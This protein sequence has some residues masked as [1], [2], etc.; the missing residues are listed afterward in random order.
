MNACIL[1][2]EEIA[3]ACPHIHNARLSAL[4]DVTDTACKYQKC[5]LTGLGRTLI[6]SA[7]TKHCIKKIDRLLGNSHL[8]S[9]RKDIYKALA[10]RFVQVGSY[11]VIL[12]DWSQINEEAGFH[13]LRAS[14]ASEGRAITLYEEV[15]PKNKSH[16]REVH[17]AFLDVLQYI[18]PADVQPLLITDAG[19]KN[20]WFKQVQRKG[21]Y[22]LGRIR[23][24]TQFKTQDTEKW[25][26]CRSLNDLATNNPTYLGRIELAKRNAIVCCAHL[27]KKP[28]QGRTKRTQGKRV[29]QR[30]NSR[31]YSARER[32]PWFL[33]TNIP[34]EK[35][36]SNQAVALYTTRMQIEENFR[37]TKN[38]RIGL[39][40]KESKSRTEQRLEI[41][42]L[43]VFLATHILWLIGIKATSVGL[44]KHYQA[45]TIRDRAVLSM[46]NLGLQVLR[47]Q[48]ELI[49]LFLL[50][51]LMEIVHSKGKLWN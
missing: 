10:S 42:L 20:P 4:L 43:V 38:Q 31:S 12:I 28:L 41:L 2:H 27:Y 26:P 14:L 18:L 24:F 35:L 36:S 40:L 49:H 37:D 25:I 48:P 5:S 29:S 22:W 16:N 51:E 17:G 3:T 32:E 44:H 33:V 23:H 8:Q 47:K 50:K 30:T 13:I 34:H 19:F 6:S 7:K 21:W 1:L 45:N 11:P 9:E 39:S 15:H 46:F